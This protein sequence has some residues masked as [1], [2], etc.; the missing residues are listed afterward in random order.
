MLYGRGAGDMKDGIAI[1]TL[2]MKELC[3]P[4]VTN[5]K[6]MLML[7]ADEEIGGINGV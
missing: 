5:K 1:I 2:L 6:I 3:K 7:T 4:G